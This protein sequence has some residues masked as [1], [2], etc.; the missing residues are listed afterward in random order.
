MNEKQQGLRQL[1]D[2]AD[3]LRKQEEDQIS[4][5][6]Q[7]SLH[8]HSSE[9]IQ[10][11][12]YELQVHHSE[13][14]RQNDALR[15]SLARTE[16]ELARYFNHYNL[17]PVGY[18][19]IS[20]K[21]ITLEANATITTMLGVNR[22]TMINEPFS[23][24][25]LR[26]DKDIYYRLLKEALTNEKV[27]PCEFRMITSDKTTFWASLQV[28]VLEDE[29]GTKCLRVA[30]SDFSKH[31][32]AEIK[33][34]DSEEQYRLLTTQMQMG[35][36]LHD[37][38]CDDDGTPV[39]YRFISVNERYE[40]L[41]G[42]HKE[43]IIG[44]TILEVLPNIEK[45]WIE[46][47]GRVAL[48]GKTYRFE[49]Y[50]AELGRYYSTIVYSPKAGQFAVI[51]DD[52]TE[53]KTKEELV[54]KSEEKF[55]Q[56]VE[57]IDEVFWLRSADDSELLYINPA[58]EKVW[59]KTC[60][61]LYDNPESFFDAIYDV[62]K[63]AIFSVIEKAKTDETVNEYRIVRPNG[64]LRWVNTKTF[65]VRNSDGEITNRT[66]IA[67]DVTERIQQ[68]EMLKESQKLLSETESI[69]NIG[70]WSINIDTMDVKWTDEVYRIHEIEL[71]SNT[72]VDMGIN[73]Y[74]KES[75]TLIENA[76]KRAIEHGENYDLELEFITIKGNKRAVHTIGKADLTNRRLYGFIQDITDRKEMEKQLFGEK[77]KFKTT[78][79]S[80]GDGVF[81]VT[82][83]GIVLIMNK[84]SEQLT[85][86][87]QEEAVGRSIEEVFYIIN[88]STRER[89]ENPVSKVLQTGSKI[90]LSDQTLLISKGGIE[91]PIENSASP[92]KDEQGNITGV[93]LVFSDFTEK[94]KNRD[95]ITYISFHDHLTGLYNRRF[96]EAEVVR[97]DTK[98]NLPMSIIMGDVNGLK[99]IN[100]SFGHSVGDA[101]LIKTAEILKKSFRADDII[102]RVGGDEFVVL[103]PKTND[104]EAR[105]LV[106]RVINSLKKEKL[107]GLDVSA[108]FGLATKMDMSESTSLI[109]KQAEDFMYYN[110]LFEGPSVRGRVINNIVASINSKS[111]REKD[112]KS[113][114]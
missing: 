61:S 1:Y 82:T 49:N 26:E 108:S 105:E 107:N 4:S 15:M 104:S 27:L 32:T 36:A 102:A 57:N 96:F 17:A 21:G 91:I 35:L 47:F 25:I 34:R 63:P 37:I 70:G 69:G 53:R 58:Y 98:R 92:I 30:I 24:F 43:G 74:T 72:S 50:A 51:V 77:E 112:R 68:S 19:I 6:D 12:L 48:T 33:L 93:V 39:D 114:V 31:K 84:V 9:E 60:Q 44:K 64:E 66:G 99:L 23:A 76:V 62:D 54:R 40:Q 67:V 78:L 55:R 13:L 89:C 71:N 88:E 79:L 42:L 103:L 20:E 110:K 85:G 73:Y 65:F 7:I 94:K 52:V 16:A 28:K 5:E 41:T 87:T 86:W 100:D 45:Y 111:P 101:L 29:D 109:I 3:I 8:T 59:G 97:L 106:D 10:K 11:M 22:Q 90:E 75:R 46:T 80:I 113:V 14:E 83:Q 2:D 38:I 18:C 95:K 56:I 81:S